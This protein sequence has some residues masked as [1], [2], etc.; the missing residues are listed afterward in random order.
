MVASNKR[1]DAFENI[2][3]LFHPLQLSL[4]PIADLSLLTPIY[5]W[6]YS[7][8]AWLSKKLFYRIKFAKPI[9]TKTLCSIVGE[10]CTPKSPGCLRVY[11]TRSGLLNEYM[12]RHCVQHKYVG[13]VLHRVSLLNKY[14]QRHCAIWYVGYVLQRALAVW[15]TTYLHLVIF[16]GARQPL[17]YH[18]LVTTTSALKLLQLRWYSILFL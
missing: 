9:L 16:M 11:P 2:L 12:Q 17:G 6:E 3:L 13:Y 10:V 18:H 8:E 5:T 14:R 15:R 4:L 7:R 1:R